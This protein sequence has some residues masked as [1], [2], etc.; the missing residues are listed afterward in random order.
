MSVY[1]LETAHTSESKLTMNK[2][3]KQS[4]SFNTW[5]TD[6]EALMFI[7]LCGLFEGEGIQ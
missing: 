6:L 1:M 5:V 2:K 7:T 4:Q 3:G